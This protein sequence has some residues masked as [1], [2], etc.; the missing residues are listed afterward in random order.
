[1]RIVSPAANT[2][3]KIA[4]DASPPQIMLKTDGQGPHVWTWTMS[5][6]RFRK[7]G[8]VNT[9]DGNLTLQN[10][11]ADVGGTLL[12]QV[13]VGSNQ[14]SV[15]LKVIGTNPST[16][17]L[18]TYI[19]AQPNNDDFYAIVN[20]ETQG[21]NFDRRG[22]PK[23]SFDGGYG[24]SQLTTPAPTYAQCWSWKRNVD[25]G[26]ALLATKRLAA[27]TYLS[28]HGTY[29]HDQLRRETVA[30]WNGGAYH[31]WDGRNWVRPANIVCAPGT[32]NIGWDTNDPDNANMTQQQLLTRDRQT[33][34]NP[35]TPNRHW[36][37]TGIC[38]AD[39][40]IP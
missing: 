35:H 33:F 17:E 5:W 2:Q 21:L 26:L 4:S 7:Q 9:P 1:M 27:T 40:L 23:V 25:G 13:R 16:T 37:Y 22:E 29:T 39:A 18:T 34:S 31:Q 38:Y 30:R 36:R 8:T 6:R 3:F 12:I 15:Q 24:M 14:A 28:A 10:E 19:N 32:G 11:I 20:H